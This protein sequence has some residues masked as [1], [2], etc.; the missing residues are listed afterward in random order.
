[1]LP[2]SL[3]KQFRGARQHLIMAKIDKPTK[4]S[5]LIVGQQLIQV[6]RCFFR[7]AMQTKS[8]IHLVAY[9]V[10]NRILDSPKSTLVSLKIWRFPTRQ[11]SGNL[12]VQ[13]ESLRGFAINVGFQITLT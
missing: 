1:M 3:Q 8:L 6:P 11:A 7:S 13:I 2:T 10:D 4:V 9:P 5:R 12:M